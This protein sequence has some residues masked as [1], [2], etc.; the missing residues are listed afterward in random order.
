D[1]LVTRPEER[2]RGIEQRLLAAGARDDLIFTVVDAIISAIALADRA[3]QFGGAADRR[4]LREMLIDRLLGGRV[5]EIRRPEIR[6][7][8]AEVD[9]LD[10]LAAQPIHGGRDLHG[11]RRGDPRGAIRET[12]HREFTF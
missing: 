12:N 11:L 2:Q 8:G 3:L 4:V 9:D 6:L 5:D 7:A 10:T 1:D